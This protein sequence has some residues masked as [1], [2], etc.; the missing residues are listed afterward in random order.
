LDAKKIVGNFL[1]VFVGREMSPHEDSF[2]DQ[3]SE[4]MWIL[5]VHNNIRKTWHAKCGSFVQN[6]AYKK[7]F[8]FPIKIHKYPVNQASTYVII[9]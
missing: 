4:S 8:D 5:N 7:R 1:S 6:G 2:R 3:N 9:S